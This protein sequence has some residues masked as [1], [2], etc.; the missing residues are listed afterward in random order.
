MPY[1]RVPLK[2]NFRRVPVV[3]VG[4]EGILKTKGKNFVVIDVRGVSFQVYVSV[5]TLA[6]G[7]V[8]DNIRLHTHLQLKDDS[9]SL[10]GFSS[11][12]E[13]ELFE[14]L[15]S[16]S[17]VGAKVALALLS[18]LSPEQLATAITSENTTVLSQI[19]GVGKKIAGRLVLELKSKVAKS[20]LVTA[21]LPSTA[22]NK[23]MR[24]AL[25]GLGYS[26]VEINSALASL[27]NSADL[28]F[29]EKI[30]LALQY[31]VR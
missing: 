24:S 17:G 22:N 6:L 11:E 30:K 8:G 9:A 31:F 2:E 5:M 14:L 4:L 7:Q 25:S 13:L 28:S 18:A 15:T 29:E 16:V 1:L 23:D 20:N 19:P 21:S 3:I 27:P 26:A 10:Y 12:E